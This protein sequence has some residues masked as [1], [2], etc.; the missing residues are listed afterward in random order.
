MLHYVMREH[1]RAWHKAVPF[2]VWCMREIPSATLGVSPFVMQQQQPVGDG[3]DA[4]L[5]HCKSTWLGERR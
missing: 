1:G 3:L 4:P 2:I 5:G